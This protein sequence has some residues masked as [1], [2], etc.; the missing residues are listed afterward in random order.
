MKGYCDFTCRPCGIDVF[1]CYDDD[2]TMKGMDKTLYSSGWLNPCTLVCDTLLPPPNTAFIDHR[3]L[4]GINIYCSVTCLMSIGAV[5]VTTNFRNEPVTNLYLIKFR[6]LY[7]FFAKYDVSY[8]MI[9][10]WS[11]FYSW[12]NAIS[13]QIYSFGCDYS[14]YTCP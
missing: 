10:I 5:L 3:H 7:K 8:E 6:S 4:Y 2:V 13:F 9:A 11:R 14:L 12:C 1:H